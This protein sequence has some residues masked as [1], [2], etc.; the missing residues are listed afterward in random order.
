MDEKLFLCRCM[1]G[2]PVFKSDLGQPVSEVNQQGVKDVLRTIISKYSSCAV[3]A[4]DDE[5]NDSI[6][7]VLWFYPSIIK[8]KMNNTSFCIQDPDEVR[9]LMK[10]KAFFRKAPSLKDIPDSQRSLDIECIQVVKNEGEKEWI[11]WKQYIGKNIGRN[12]VRHLQDWSKKKKWKK[13]YATA[14][15]EI[16]PLRYW[17]GSYTLDKFISLGFK[18]IPDSKAFHPEVVEA[19][20]NMKQGLH[21][22]KVQRMWSQYSHLTEDEIA[23]TYKVVYKI[24]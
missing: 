23:C 17:W 21:G 18:V 7:G 8:E 5:L 11:S 9:K 6:I 20:K 3:I 1:H 12:M 13:I 19:V 16:K 22:E 4:R 2:G 10:F 15:P 24:D 14:I